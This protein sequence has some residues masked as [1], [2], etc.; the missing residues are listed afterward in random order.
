MVYSFNKV[1]ID[2]RLSSTNPPRIKILRNLQERNFSFPSLKKEINLQSKYASEI[3]EVIND[4][5]GKSRNKQKLNLFT[6]L[7]VPQV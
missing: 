4:L 5:E 3:F 2:E 7:R 1:S 6:D